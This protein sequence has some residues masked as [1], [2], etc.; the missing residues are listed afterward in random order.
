MGKKSTSLILT[1]NRNMGRSCS[2]NTKFKLFTK[3]N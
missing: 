1:G 2:K 3:E